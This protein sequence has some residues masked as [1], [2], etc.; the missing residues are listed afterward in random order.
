MIT[1]L[2]LYLKLT[3][4]ISFMYYDFTIVK[5]CFS[6]KFFIAFENLLLVSSPSVDIDIAETLF[7]NLRKFLSLLTIYWHLKHIFFLCL[8]N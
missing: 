4:K 3:V 6:Y 5:N 1:K 8:R 2:Q 7:K